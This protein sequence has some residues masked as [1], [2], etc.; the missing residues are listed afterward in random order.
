[1]RE[2]IATAELDLD[3]DPTHLKRAM[4]AELDRER[5]QQLGEELPIK[6]AGML[7]QILP[8]VRAVS[9]LLS[10]HVG[11]PSVVWA[12]IGPRKRLIWLCG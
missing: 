4:L 1:M 2:R 3:L 9:T 6:V 8:R 5:R 7:P 12:T 10:C 11:P